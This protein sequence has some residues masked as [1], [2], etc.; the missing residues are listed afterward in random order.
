MVSIKINDKD[1]FMN[2]LI[3]GQIFDDFNMTECEIDTFVK[4]NIDGRINSDYFDTPYERDFVSWKDFKQYFTS[5]IKGDRAPGK[6]KLVLSIPKKGYEGFV[7]SNSLPIKPENISG[8]YMNI[9]YSLKD[10]HIITATSLNIFTM[11]KDVDYAW[12]N[13]VKIILTKNF[14][15]DI[16]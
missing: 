12:D 8:L 4:Y 6:I 3:S 1:N 13:T 15:A 14:N 5:I 2:A 7:N 9:N 10:L 11:S 16:L